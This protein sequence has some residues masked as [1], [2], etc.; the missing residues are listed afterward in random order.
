MSKRGV[1]AKGGAMPT[2]GQASRRAALGALVGASALALPTISAV[3]DAAPDPTFTAIERHRLAWASIGALAPSVDEVAAK[4]RGRAVT[5]ADWDGYERASAIE[6]HALEELLSTPPSAAAGARAAI[7]HFL[8][9]DDGR[10]P[11]DIGRFLAT[12]LKSAL[13][14]V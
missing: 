2:E 4:R 10:L 14:D 7:E 12:L 5:Q 11:E 6:R 8:A 9:F 13:F 3:A 1:S